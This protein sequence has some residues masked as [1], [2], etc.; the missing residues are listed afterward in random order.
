MNYRCRL[1]LSG[2]SSTA[3]GRSDPGGSIHPPGSCSEYIFSILWLPSSSVS[4]SYCNL[5]DAMRGRLGRHSCMSS[6]FPIAMLNG[7]CFFR[8][9]K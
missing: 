8:E 5:T 3:S 6:T 2:K 9:S 7:T 1:G 4:L